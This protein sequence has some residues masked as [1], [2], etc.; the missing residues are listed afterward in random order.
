VIFFLNLT[1]I[2]KEYL[3]F[4]KNRMSKKSILFTICFIVSFVAIISIKA[5]FV[6]KNNSVSVNK[7]KKIVGI[8]PSYSIEKKKEG[9]WQKYYN[10]HLLRDRYLDS[11]EDVCDNVSFV[12]LP[13]SKTRSEELLSIVD[14]IIITG[15]LDIDGKYF[16]Q[17]TSDK[18]TDIEP[19]RR[20]KFTIDAV[21]HAMKNNKPLLGV[22]NGMQIINIV[23]GGD[24][25]QDINSM[26]E[27][28]LPH[29]GN[30]DFYNYR[31]N[32]KVDNDSWLFR[33]VKKENIKVNSA[34]H[35]SV[36]K[37]GEN[38]KITAVADDGII[39]ALECSNC[40]KPIVGVQWHPEF[41]MTKYDKK[42]IKSFCDA[43]AND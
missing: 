3:F 25:I 17:K 43:V 30:G 42:I 8:I 10:Y 39:E 38:I 40:K 37:I 35:Q 27:N 1:F 2:F 7:T 4:L 24:L 32:I 28:S 6:K 19:E 9:K 41:L 12:I 16:N 13:I 29:S 23:N 36:G 34:H 20:T 31:H 14:G 26:V 11:F 33:A 5:F 18:V 22:C 15:G 21:K